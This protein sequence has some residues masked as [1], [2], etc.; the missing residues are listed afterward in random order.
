MTS[1]DYE[2]H[3]LRSLPD[4]RQDLD[5]AL[6]H[7]NDDPATQR[8]PLV[9]SG[10][11][12]WIF[13]TGCFFIEMVL[14]GFPFSFG[15][16]QEYYSTHPPISSQPHS[17]SAVGTT[18]SG[19]L[20]LFAPVT[21][22]HCTLSP[23][24]RRYSCFYALPPLILSLILSSYAKT[25]PHLILTQG[26]LYGVSGCYLYYPVFLYIDE[27]FVRRKAFAYGVMWAGSGSGGL[28]G[29]FVLS[30]GLRRY[31]APTFL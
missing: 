18:C 10:L 4:P 6:S 7:S 26:L 23:H 25:V 22:L 12:A 3:G 20:Y 1:T 5:D 9:D 30:W 21:F 14:W 27:W 16:L 17:I 11:S 13:L 19:I 29:P 31:G 28:A 2:S 15:V 24:V 8:L